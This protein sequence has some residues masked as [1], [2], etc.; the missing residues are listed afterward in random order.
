MSIT[1]EKIS[2]KDALQMYIG[3]KYTEHDYDIYLKMKNI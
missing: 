3:D 2:I 1:K